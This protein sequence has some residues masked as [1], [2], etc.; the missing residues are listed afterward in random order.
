MQKQKKKAVLSALT[1]TFSF[2]VAI[3]PKLAQGR[4]TLETLPKG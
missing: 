2:L 3:V 1:R 4:G